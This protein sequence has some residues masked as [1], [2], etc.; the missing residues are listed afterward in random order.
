MAKVLSMGGE[1]LMLKDPDCFYITK[2][3]DR[4]QKV[5]KFDDDEA[6]VISH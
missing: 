3:T 4:L 2:R 6:I 5:K 1:G